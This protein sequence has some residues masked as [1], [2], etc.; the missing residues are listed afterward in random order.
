[1]ARAAKP[2]PDGYR[3]IT[4]YLVVR[5]AADALEFYK[6]AFGAKE[7]MRMAAPGGRIG[8]AEIEIGGSRIMLT[9]EFP[10]MGARAPQSPG[11]T[12]VMIYLYVDDV[13]QTVKAALAAGAKTGRPV[14]DQFYGDRSGSLTDPF[15]HLWWVATHKEDVPIDEIRRRAEQRMKQQGG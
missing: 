8:H 12:P 14:E 3:S 6:R 13:D 2:I 4:P 15:G 10:E 1:M 5:G 11:A 9:D 7:I